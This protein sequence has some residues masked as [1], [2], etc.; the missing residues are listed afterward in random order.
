MAGSTQK[1]FRGGL[2][3]CGCFASNHLH[4]WQEVEGAEITAVCDR[5]AERAQAYGERFSVKEVYSEVSG[6]LDAAELDF[7]DIVTTPETHRELVEEAASRGLH[8]ICQ[9]PMAPSVEDAG[10]MVEACRSAGV[11][12][13]VHENFRWQAPMRAVKA[14]GES[15]GPIHFARLSFRSGFDVY[16]RQ[17][18]LA[19]DEH[20][21]IYDLGVHLLDLA[22]Y[23]V[24]EIE[25]FHCET[26]RVNPRIRG[27]DVATVLLRS[28]GG[29][30]VVVELSY[31][32][33]PIE[34]RFPETLVLLEGRDGTVHL[35]PGFQLTVR[36]SSG[37]SSRP[38]PPDER[39][40]AAPPAHAIQDSVVRI[41]Q[42]WVDCLRDGRTPE[43]S[44]DDNLKTL[45]LVFGAYASA[46]SGAVFVPRKGR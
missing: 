5:Q 36:S 22:R 34:E 26:R 17:P 4:A 33:K 29:A 14:A 7:V 27:E 15:I 41:Q 42:H 46:E 1:V 39:S 31:G 20:F 6:M 21:I 30:N 10:A 8:V 40:W 28:R 45:E 2:V 12:F 32:S 44:G 19:E 18:Y 3:G 13:M 11:R 25:R 9:K 37:L 24:G 23:F 38:A 43:T 35:G 16:S